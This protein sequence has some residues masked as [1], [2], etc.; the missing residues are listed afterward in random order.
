MRFYLVVLAVLFCVGIFFSDS[1][2]VDN[3]GAPLVV[4]TS[5]IGRMTN[6][7]TG[8]NVV[9]LLRKGHK[10]KPFLYHKIEYKFKY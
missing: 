6:K 1:C 9:T 8:D 5:A 4:N 7:F 2:A 3:L 10:I